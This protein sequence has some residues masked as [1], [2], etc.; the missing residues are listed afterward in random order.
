MIQERITEKS[1]PEKIRVPTKDSDPRLDISK[2]SV[3][4]PRKNIGDFDLGFLGGPQKRTGF[5][6]SLW[7]WLSATIDALVIMC[8]SC[9][10][11]IGLSFLVKTEFK[12][13]LGF[14][15]SRGNLG[16]TFTVLFLFIG[17]MYFITAR[18]L[19]GASVG[20]WACSLRMGQPHERVQNYYLSR[21]I[22]RT[23]LTLLTGIILF[24][25]LS[26]IFKKDLSGKITGLYIYSLK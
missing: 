18:T 7:M 5:K 11:M 9:A 15:I 25:L 8:V 6:L 14:T 20:E 26:L 24:P 22:L 12:E 10:T 13:V 3:V 4:F 2:T 17:W 19:A 21:V 1:Q 23:T 16:L